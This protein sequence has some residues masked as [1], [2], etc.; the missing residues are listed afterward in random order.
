MSALEQ[1]MDAPT[2]T[3]NMTLSAN[4]WSRLGADLEARAGGSDLAR[5][6]ANAIRAMV[7]A[8]DC[9]A[10]SGLPDTTPRLVFRFGVKV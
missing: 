5:S 8:V 6:M 10:A 9:A 2:L 7:A 1:G 4:E 3:L